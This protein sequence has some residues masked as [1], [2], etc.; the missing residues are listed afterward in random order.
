MEDLVKVSTIWTPISFF[1]VSAIFSSTSG[2]DHSFRSFNLPLGDKVNSSRFQFDGYRDTI[3]A[4]RLIVDSPKIRLVSYHVKNEDPFAIKDE[5]HCEKGEC[6]E[7]VEP[8]KDIK[9][10]EAEDEINEWI[11]R[12]NVTKMVIECRSKSGVVEWDYDGKGVT[13]ITINC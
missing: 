1:L 3:S 7:I 10:G 9:L 13:K 4:A 5:L 6:S 11:V 2:L 8:P 12:P